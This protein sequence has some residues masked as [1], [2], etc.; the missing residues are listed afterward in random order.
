MT[1]DLIVFDP[2][3]ES[4]DVALVFKKDGDLLITHNVPEVRAGGVVKGKDAAGF[5]LAIACTVAM[6]NED[7]SSALLVE[8]AR[9]LEAMS[10]PAAPGS[11]N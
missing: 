8:A 6:G 11:I 2:K 10:F 3:L 9:R 5:L 4:G 1:E 7:I